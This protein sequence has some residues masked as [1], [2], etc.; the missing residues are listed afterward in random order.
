MTRTPVRHFSIKA[1]KLYLIRSRTTT[2]Y[3]DPWTT[4]APFLFK[5]SCFC[6]NLKS[7][8]V[9][10]YILMS[11]CYCRTIKLNQRKYVIN[12]LFVQ[13]AEEPSQAL[14]FFFLIHNKFVM[15]NQSTEPWLTVFTNKP[16][17]KLQTSV[18]Q[19]LWRGKTFGRISSDHNEGT[20][21]T[22]FSLTKNSGQDQ[23]SI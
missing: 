6:S 10:K 14:F 23:L 8:L 7:L 12:L 15:R 20:V 19:T 16:G 9:A 13:E 18:Y 11:F 2:V 3:L 21:K 1:R 17:L 5:F 22:N 4:I